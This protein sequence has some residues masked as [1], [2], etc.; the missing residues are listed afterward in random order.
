MGLRRFWPMAALRAAPQ[1]FQVCARGARL[2]I[3]QNRQQ[4]GSTD[5]CHGLLAYKLIAQ[6]G[7]Y[8]DQGRGQIVRSLTELMELL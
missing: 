8:Y 7:I 6:M 1:T 2:A 5:F 4:R 3:G